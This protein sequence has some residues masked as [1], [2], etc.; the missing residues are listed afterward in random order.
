MTTEAK[1]GLFTLLGIAILGFILVHMS[2]FRF[3]ADKDYTVYAGFSQVMGLN[4]D[5][6]VR[7]AGVEAGKVKSIEPDG[8]GVRVELKIK[9]DIKVPKDAKITVSMSGVMGEKFIS[10][11][12]G[13]HPS[14]EFL[15]NG[16]YVIGTDEEGMDSMMEGMGK[17]IEQVQQLLTSLNEVMGNPQLKSSVVRSAENIR[18]VTGNIKDMTA[19]FSRMAIQ[20]EGNANQMIQNMTHMTNSLMQAA[21]GVNQLIANY[22]GDGEEGAN[23]RLALVNIASASSHVENMAAHLD[24]LVTDPQVSDDLKTTLHNAR[25]VSQRANDMLN[26]FGGVQMDTGVDVLYS[27]KADRWM[28]NF[29]L[30][31]HR[32][33]GSFLTLGL[34]DIGEDNLFNAQVGVRQGALAGRAGAIDGK[35]GV[36]FDA[37]TSGD[38]WKFSADAYN[39]N[40]A[41]L[42]LR[43]QYRIT[44][45]TYLFG[46]MNDVNKSEKRTTYV[47][48]RHT[49]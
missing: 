26:N 13:K 19:V 43:A 25:T 39:I 47:G 27:G 4:P 20:N 6:N 8:M 23:I 40:N 24:G 35:L 44:S 5:A 28:T 46:Q 29:D 38:R 21:D 30:T 18:D 9:P 48:V 42:K 7:F 45:D 3:G 41:A 10:I 12:P 16:D 15:Q 11:V 37:Y 1:V 2:G 36:G 17:T 49:F 31:L 22:S 34:N 32:D 14:D 33:P